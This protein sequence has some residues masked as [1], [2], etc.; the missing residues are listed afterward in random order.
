M[1][2]RERRNA[3]SMHGMVNEFSGFVAGGGT[4]KNIRDRLMETGSDPYNSGL[5]DGFFCL[6]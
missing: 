6:L 3:V 2:K 1:V 5:Y 4:G